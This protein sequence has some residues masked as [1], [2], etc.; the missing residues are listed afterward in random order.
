MLRASFTKLCKSLESNI[1]VYNNFYNNTFTKGCG[2]Y[3][4]D[5][6]DKKYLDCLSMIGVNALGYNHNVYYNA[7]QTYMNDN[8]INQIIDMDSEI[9]TKFLSKF[10][11]FVSVSDPYFANNMRVIFT[12]PSGSDAIDCA[13]KVA[14]S[15]TGKS[16]VLTFKNSYHG[17]TQYNLSLTCLESRNYS[18]SINNEGIPRLEFPDKKAQFD[19]LDELKKYIIEYEPACL[20]IECIQGEGGINILSNKL[21]QIQE[22]LKEHNV[23]LIIDEIQT[24]IGRTGKCFAYQHY[25]LEP[26]IICVSKAIGGGQPLALIAV[27]KNISDLEMGQHLGTFRGNQI[28]F[29]TGYNCLDY[30]L[31]KDLCINAKIL[32]HYLVDK[33]NI[34]KDDY[35][36]IIRD[37]RGV[38][39]MIGVEIRC[40]KITRI[41]HQ[42]LNEVGLFVGLGGRDKNVIRLLPPL[43]FTIDNCDELLNKFEYAL[44]KVNEL[45]ILQKI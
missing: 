36:E 29:Y 14:K 35:N 7:L 37:V 11:E 26:D 44:K 9:R 5:T 10:K 43:I 20:I 41:L 42:Q 12:G 21:E 31:E 22:L 18:F 25:M 24:G 23:L 13:T 34:L 40:C 4:Y 3:L 39:L 38:G 28:A 17:V 32:G 16:N 19:I 27:H 45:Q 8:A 33:I 15:H 1:R 6:N 2:V 30:I